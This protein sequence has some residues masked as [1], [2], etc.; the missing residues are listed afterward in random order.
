MEIKSKPTTKFAT[1]FK[2]LRKREKALEIR[3][4]QK[5]YIRLINLFN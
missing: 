3:N 5:W 2:E 1:S 4:K